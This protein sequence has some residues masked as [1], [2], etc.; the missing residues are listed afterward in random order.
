[1]RERKRERMKNRQ[2]RGRGEEK[3]EVTENTL[4]SKSSEEFILV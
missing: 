3:Q 2:G 1:M 4:A